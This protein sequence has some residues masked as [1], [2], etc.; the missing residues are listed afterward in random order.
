MNTKM[1]DAEMS[2]KGYVD[3]FV[4]FIDIL[5]FKDF[6]IKNQFEAPYSL[7]DSIK[8]CYEMVV[9]MTK[10][11]S[12]TKEMLD[13]VTFNIISDSI[14]IS[15]P[16]TT[17]L[18]F[19]ILVSIVNLITFDILKNYKLLCRGGISEGYFYAENNIAFGPALVNAYVLENKIAR[20]PRII[21]TLDTL[22]VYEKISNKDF[23][24]NSSYLIYLDINDKLFFADYISYIMSA[25][26][27]LIKNKIIESNYVS[28]LFNNIKINIESNLTLFSNDAKIEEKY[29][30]FKKYY[31][32]MIFLANK[33]PQFPF[34]CDYIFG[35]N[36]PSDEKLYKQLECSQNY[37]NNTITN[38]S[39]AALGKNS[40]VKTGK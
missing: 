25:F 26:V 20:Y 40:T 19:E 18:S 12:V 21:F 1:E 39:N 31:N 37:S 34:K 6:I 13:T 16:K 10:S 23:Q 5:G 27:I 15:V 7:F 11:N 35:E 22:N 36:Y 14:V 2:E 30:Y 8:K 3:S 33:N 32:Q 38:S 9:L 24:N 29:I 17:R 28:S 4:A